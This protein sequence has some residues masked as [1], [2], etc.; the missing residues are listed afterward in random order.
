MYLVKGWIPLSLAE[1][2]TSMMWVAGEEG[3]SVSASQ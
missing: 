1:R 2:M 3:T